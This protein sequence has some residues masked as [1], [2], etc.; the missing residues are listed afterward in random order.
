[1]SEFATRMDLQRSIINAVN[2]SEQFPREELCGLS[3]SAIDRWSA[4]NIV[5][6]ESDVYKL[7]IKLSETLRFIATKS[8]EPISDDLNALSKEVS[9]LMSRLQL[10]LEKMSSKEFPRH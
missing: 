6:A 9:S 10:A 5:G 8:Q 2:E 4:I 7:L 3:Q 1:M